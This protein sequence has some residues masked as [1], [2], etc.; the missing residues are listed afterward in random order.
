MADGFRG[1]R[2]VQYLWLLPTVVIGLQDAQLV[3]RHFDRVVHISEVGQEGLDYVR[4]IDGTQTRDVLEEH[5]LAPVVLPLLLSLGWLVALSRSI[6]SIS[7]GRSWRSRQLSAFAHESLL[8][9]DL[10]FDELDDSSVA[11]IGAGGIGSQVA[12]ALAAAGVG[13]LV[14]TDSDRVDETNLNRQFLYGRGDLGRLKTDVIVSR[15]ASLFPGAKIE[16]IDI[17]HD[18]SLG[19][20]LPRTDLLVLAAED[21]RFYRIPTPISHT[22]MVLQAGYFGADAVVGPLVGTRAGTT[23]WDCYIQHNRPR[24]DYPTAPRMAGWN[25]SGTAVNAIAGGLA[26][27]VA[28]H[29]LSPRLGGLLLPGERLTVNVST[30]RCDRQTVDDGRC[31]HLDLSEWTG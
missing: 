6:H 3:L 5:P 14:V 23:C 27:Q 15:I 10:A 8:Y 29:A 13:R 24:V 21:R 31:D 2:H 28:L 19:E 7:Q 22:T 1:N 4:R 9:P 12:Y 20:A 17:D 30:L 25:A 11:I 16:G 26:A 18:V